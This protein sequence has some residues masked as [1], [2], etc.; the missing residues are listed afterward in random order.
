VGRCGLDADGPVHKSRHSNEHLSS[1]NGRQFL[2]WVTISFQ[3]GLCAMEW[4]RWLVGRSVSLSVISLK[5][6][7]CLKWLPSSQ[8]IF[9]LVLYYTEFVTVISS[10]SETSYPAFC[11]TFH[12]FIFIIEI[13][14]MY[15]VLHSIIFYYCFITF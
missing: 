7:F 2:Y 4:V 14:S 1:I 11:F 9:W 10:L 8:C 12:G 3:D 13:L 5:M 6:K 15:W